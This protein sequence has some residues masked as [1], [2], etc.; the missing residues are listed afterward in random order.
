[1][2]NCLR[3]PK[4]TERI[5]TFSELSASDS[6]NGRFK[7]ACVDCT[8]FVAEWT[9]PS[10]KRRISGNVCVSCECVLEGEMG[11]CDQLE[12]PPTHLEA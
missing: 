6:S 7:P 8:S 1:M 12:L 2:H 11:I 3:D 4:E 5:T 9:V 10:F